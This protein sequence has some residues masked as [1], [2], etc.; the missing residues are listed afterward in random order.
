MSYISDGCVRAVE[1]AH[2]NFGPG[3]IY[4]NRGNIVDCGRNRSVAAYLCNP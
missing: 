2:V 3:R 1:M 4:V